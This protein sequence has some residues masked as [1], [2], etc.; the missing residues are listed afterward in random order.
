MAPGINKIFGIG[1]S[2]TAT[3]SLT[4]A[5]EILGYR[6]SHWEDH[7]LINQHLIK[8]QFELSLLKEYDALIDSPIPSIYQELDKTYPHSKFIL[9]VRDFDSWLKSVRQHYL[10]NVGPE[11]PSFNTALGFGSWYFDEKKFSRTYYEH[12]AEVKAYFKNRPADLLILDICKGEGWE[13]LC[14]FLAKPIPDVPF[15]FK[16]QIDYSLKEGPRQHPE[17]RLKNIAGDSEP[18]LSETEL[19][20][21]EKA[22]LGKKLQAA[23]EELQAVYASKSWR[24]IRALLAPLRWFGK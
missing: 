20:E 5:L 12:E 10:V 17:L 11:N 18:S 23:Q 1:L 19:L 14:S 24:M 7:D 3:T 8:N 21:K 2:R 16:N 22:E 6:A 15:P 9:T 4:Q 13:K